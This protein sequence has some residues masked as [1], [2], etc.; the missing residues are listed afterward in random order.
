MKK[1]LSRDCRDKAGLGVRGKSGDSGEIV[2]V[3]VQLRDNGDLKV[4]L[5]VI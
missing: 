5:R 4:N 3:L 1:R 2:S